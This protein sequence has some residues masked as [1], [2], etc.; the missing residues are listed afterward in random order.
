MA[1]RTACFII[2][3]MLFTM[4]SWTPLAWLFVVGAAVLPYLA[5]VHANNA[6]QRRT[7]SVVTA[8][9][10]ALGAAA[11]SQPLVGSIVDP[12]PRDSAAA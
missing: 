12:D 3:G 7:T 8:P 6:D 9:T 2:A 1:V 11:P 5:V 4:T 10:R